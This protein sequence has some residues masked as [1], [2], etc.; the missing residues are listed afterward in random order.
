LVSG[1]LI[2]FLALILTGCGGKK[3][4][5]VAPP[6]LPP[7]TTTTSDARPPAATPS[8]TKPLAVETGMASWYGEPYHARRTANGET[9]DKNQLTAAHRTLPHNSVVRVTNVATGSSTL[10]RINDRG[11]FIEG[12]IIDLSYAAARAADVWRAGVAKVR[13]EVL[14]APKPIDTGGRWC[15]Q[16]GAFT[17]WSVA[18]RYRDKLARRYQNAR[19]I[20]FTGPT[21][22]WVRIR[23]PED[24]RRRAEEVLRDNPPPQGTPF[25][26]R[27][28]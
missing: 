15:V 3:R 24:D 16:V 14:E 13:L 25:L 27:L 21:G 28:D 19:V 26:V 4:A 17:D 9:Y 1:L 10:V 18:D 11:P 12:R 5:R 22:D 20:Q 2:V 6:A 7:S 23:V 8:D